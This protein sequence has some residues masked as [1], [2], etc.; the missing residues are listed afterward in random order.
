[1]FVVGYPLFYETL[2]EMF[3]DDEVETR[4]KNHGLELHDSDKGQVILGLKVP[5]TVYLF[6]DF[7]NV[8]KLIILILQTKIK[9]LELFKKTGIDITQY[10]FYPME[11]E[12][13][14]S[15]EEPCVFS[16]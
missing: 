8:D 14:D 1:M 3:G 6:H 13:V 9:F 10:Q 16:L 2:C 12:T 7:L 11:S 5:E 15:T 4:I